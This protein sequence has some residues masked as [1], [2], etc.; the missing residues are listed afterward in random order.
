MAGSPRMP[1]DWPGTCEVNQRPLLAMRANSGAACPSGD[2]LGMGVCR[3]RAVYPPER[4]LSVC[5]T[6]PLCWCVGDLCCVFACPSVRM[7][8]GFIGATMGV[9]LQCGERGSIAAVSVCP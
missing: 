4:V 9:R 1:V 8:P 2:G 7:G 6:G 5:L 3:S